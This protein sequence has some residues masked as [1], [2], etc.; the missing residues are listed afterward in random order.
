MFLEV[1]QEI[2]ALQYSFPELG[3][4]PKHIPEL[5][6]HIGDRIFGYSVFEQFGELGKYLLLFVGEL[7]YCFVWVLAVGGEVGDG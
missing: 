1:S 7:L 4:I 6:Q 2:M 5:L 3:D